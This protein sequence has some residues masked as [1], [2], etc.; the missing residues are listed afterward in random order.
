MA[1]MKTATDADAMARMQPV[2]GHPNETSHAVDP[3]PNDGEIH[4]Y[5]LRA[6]V[7][8]LV[9]DGGNIVVQTGDQGAFVVDTG[10]GA[11]ADKTIAAIRKLTLGRSSLS[12]T[13]A[14]GRITP[15]A[16]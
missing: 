14:I 12:R 10:T 6:S 11:L 8:L 13:P 5:P 9:G 1:K 16:T 4:V 7:Y 15:E 3:E 2:P